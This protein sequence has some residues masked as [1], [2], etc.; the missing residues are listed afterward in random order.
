[1]TEISI[2]KAEENEVESF[3]QWGLDEG[4]NMPLKDPPTY[5]QSYPEGWRIAEV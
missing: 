4:W 1:M 5:Y 2:R 3:I